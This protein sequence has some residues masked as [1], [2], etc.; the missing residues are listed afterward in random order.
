MPLFV[1]R[2][3]S[4]NAIEQVINNSA[5]ELLCL[6]QRDAEKEDVS[7]KDLYR[8]G[9]SMRI[10]QAVNMLDGTMKLLAEGVA[11]VRVSRITFD[12]SNRIFKASGEVFNTIDQVSDELKTLSRDAG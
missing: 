10:L 2:E 5:V 8:Y 12:K 9:T 6:A 3:M 11:R 4:V 7:V 1:G